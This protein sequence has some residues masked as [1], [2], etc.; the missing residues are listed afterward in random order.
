ML[1]HDRT[2]L[3]VAGSND[4]HD[5]FGADYDVFVVE[6]DPASL[7]PVSDAVRITAHEAVDRYPDVW[8]DPA[9]APRRAAGRV[10]RPTRAELRPG[11][12][13][14]LRRVLPGCGRARTVPTA[15]RRKPRAR[16]W[17]NMAR[18]GP[19]GAAGWG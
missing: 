12:G 16:S 13:R 8:R 3:A 9:S 11:S 1:S 17:S 15:A 6:L 4:D 10:P 18:P 14:P 5:H 19:I 7:V 2:L